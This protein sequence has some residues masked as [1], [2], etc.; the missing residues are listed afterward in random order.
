MRLIGRPI[1]GSAGAFQSLQWQ[2]VGFPLG[3]L[4]IIFR[5]LKMR[6][7]RLVPPTPQAIGNNSF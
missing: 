2:Q 6:E 5:A 1:S 3:G 4:S 7:E